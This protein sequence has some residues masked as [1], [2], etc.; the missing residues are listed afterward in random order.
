MNETEIAEN[1]AVLPKENIPKALLFGTGAGI[2]AAAAWIVLMIVIGIPLLGGFVGGAL[3]GV[4]AVVISSAYKLGPARKNIIGFLVML[5]V[6]IIL[7]CVVLV[8][9]IGLAD[10]NEIG[11]ESV[12]YFAVNA[13]NLIV[14]G[15]AP[16]LFRAPHNVTIA[17]I[18]G[19][20]PIMFTSLVFG[21]EKKEKAK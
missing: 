1:S 7:S 19:L 11:G 10:Y 18:L 17:I 21:K 5:I 6:V 9:G 2:L 14:A 3:A 13:F 4:F 12:F 8:F 16:H 15:D 20:P